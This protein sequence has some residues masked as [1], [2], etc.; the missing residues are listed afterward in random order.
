MK[1]KRALPWALLA[2]TTVLAACTTTPTSTPAAAVAAPP[3]PEAPITP[4]AAANMANNCFTCHGPDGASPGAIPS[5]NKLGADN[6][7]SMLKAFK[8]GERPSTVMARHA[9]GYTDA[10][11]EALANHI[12]GL[13]RNN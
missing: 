13:N 8:S 12:A 9:K 11:I 5:L 6:I 1:L 4:A 2:A 7:R 3:K 10:E